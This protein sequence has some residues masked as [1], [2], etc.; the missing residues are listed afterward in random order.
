MSL[1]NIPAGG[2]VAL[3]YD[4]LLTLDDEIAYVWKQKHSFP[5]ILYLANKYIVTIVLFLC[6]ICASFTTSPSSFINN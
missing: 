2:F 5:K 3:S 4:I 6:V 1:N